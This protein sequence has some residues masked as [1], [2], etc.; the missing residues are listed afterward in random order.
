MKW[1]ARIFVF[2]I[3]L[4]FGT[5]AASLFW[6][7]S[8]QEVTAVAA[9]VPV[10]IAPIAAVKTPIGAESLLGSWKGTWDHNNGDCTIEIDRVNGNAFYGTLRKEGAVVLFEGK[11]NPETRILSFNET[12]VVRLG[13]Y[14]EWSLGE[15]SGFISPDGRTLV[16]SGRD[17]WGWYG[18]TASNY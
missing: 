7:S 2:T 16:G 18:W 10:R 1:I 4:V 6:D 5:F 3:A 12:K 9:D 17:K 8:R 13:P 14:T 11:F 15:N